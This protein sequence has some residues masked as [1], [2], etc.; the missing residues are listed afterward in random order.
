MK[1]IVAGR[2]DGLGARL[3]NYLSARRLAKV[4]D[5]KFIALWSELPSVHDYQGGLDDL[6]DPAMEA[7]FYPFKWS[8]ERW[9]RENITPD[10]GYSSVECI[11]QDRL[12]ILP[13]ENPDK[14]HEQLRSLFTGLPFAE[15][16][17]VQM[18]NINQWFAIQ[19][20][21]H[22]PMTGIHLRAGDVARQGI[23]Y[24][25]S[26][27]YPE[28]FYYVLLKKLAQTHQ[29]Q[30]YLAS[31]DREALY[32][33]K[34]DYGTFDFTDFRVEAS[35]K[36]IQLDLLELYALAQCERIIA[37]PGSAYSRV[38]HMIGHGT[39]ED[40]GNYFF[41]ENIKDSLIK[42]LQKANTQHIEA[43]Y[44]LGVGLL[45]QDQVAA[46]GM[47]FETVASMNPYHKGAKLALRRLK[48]IQIQAGDDDCL[49][50]I[51]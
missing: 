26:K 48:K 20:E 1:L 40:I 39:N 14:V 41:D 30:V 38:A 23:N 8:S 17:R 3:G 44:E 11:K 9:I 34:K 12:V 21:R 42:F 18:D 6:F 36:P 24:F 16:I 46:A 37:P 35:L 28:E 25:G 13:G 49:P 31:N 33:C 4:Q 50:E 7:P 27:Y 43:T 22:G 2:R 5:C 15:T 19:K 32:R 51:E 47:V 45:A 29:G 10:Q